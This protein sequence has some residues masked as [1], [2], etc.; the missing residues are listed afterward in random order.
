MSGDRVRVTVDE[1][2]PEETDEEE[3][4]VVDW[5]V[6]EGASVEAGAT[7]CTVQVEKVDIDV[8]APAGG[9]VDEIVVEE[10]GVCGPGDTL[11]WIVP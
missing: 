6:S 2:W 11:A 5:F 1:V 8:P 3:A 4:V 7:L 9:T 10:D